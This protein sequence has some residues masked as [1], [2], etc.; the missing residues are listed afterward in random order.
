MKRSASAFQIASV[1]GLAALVLGVTARPASAGLFGP[2]TVVVA[3]PAYPAYLTP[4]PVAT[5]YTAPVSPVVA[6]PVFDTD[7]VP[8][9]YYTT[10]TVVSTPVATTYV[11]PRVYSAPV[12]VAPPARVKV[13]YPRR[14]YRFAY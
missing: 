1:L 6:A 9:A 7:L 3:T 14:V 5:V 4:A 12:V 11:A 2:R 10:S 13:V 8:A